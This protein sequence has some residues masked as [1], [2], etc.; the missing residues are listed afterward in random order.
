MSAN[1]AI[2]QSI[3]T[4]ELSEKIEELRSRLIPLVIEKGFQDPR[5]LSISQELDGLINWYYIIAK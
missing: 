1:E 4:E 2:D 5:V 3:S